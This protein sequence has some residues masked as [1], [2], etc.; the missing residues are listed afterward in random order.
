MD[1]SERERSRLDQI[2]DFCADTTAHGLARVAAA[3]SW[4]ARLFWMV[5][6]IF[7]STLG[8]YQITL[9]VTAYLQY[10]TK[11]DVFLVSKENL[12]F[13]AVTVCNINPF[14]QS[15]LKN[16]PL[17]Q[18]LVSIF[19][20]ILC[21]AVDYLLVSTYKVVEHIVELLINK[22]FSLFI[23]FLLIVVTKKCIS[24][25]RRKVLLLSFQ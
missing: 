9:S 4:P 12:S 21:F 16:S 25:V 20:L 7:A 15:K 17:R 5:V 1:D 3:K 8:V 23:F 14:K 24:S 10:R 6:V 11:T 18:K 13:P 22:L 2:R 19:F